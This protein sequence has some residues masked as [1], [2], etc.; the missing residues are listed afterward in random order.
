MPEYISQH[1]HMHN[2]YTHAHTCTLPTKKKE[3]KFWKDKAFFEAEKMVKTRD[4]S[5]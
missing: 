5:G 3:G 4:F 1:S 2:V